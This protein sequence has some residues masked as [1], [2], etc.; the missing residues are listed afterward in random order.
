MKRKAFARQCWATFS[1]MGLPQVVQVLPVA[2]AVSELACAKFAPCPSAGVTGAAGSG[3]CIA[4]AWV[5]LSAAVA[6]AVAAAVVA[7]MAGMAA[8]GGVDRGGMK[9]GSASGF[10]GRC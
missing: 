1:V 8:V 2:Q 4:V 9:S 3:I 6:C 10:A 5:V 7:V